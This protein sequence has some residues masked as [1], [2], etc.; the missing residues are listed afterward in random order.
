MDT[1]ETKGGG[2][3]HILPGTYDLNDTSPTIGATEL[4][5]IMGVV[6]E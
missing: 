2:T 3:V 5:N 6:K 4:V 1:L